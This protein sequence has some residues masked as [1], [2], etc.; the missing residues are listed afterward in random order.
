MPAFKPT[1]EQRR[2][3]EGMSG[4]GIKHADICQLVINPRTGKPLDPMCL[5]K[6]FR[7]ELDTGHVKANAAVAKSLY[8]QALAG[9]VTAAIWWTKARMNWSETAK[10][11]H[12]GKDGTPIVPVI[13]LLGKPESVE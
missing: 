1:D 12:A 11:E 7:S 5:R 10:I 2:I 9:N 13:N 4:F 6:H 3:V 8:N